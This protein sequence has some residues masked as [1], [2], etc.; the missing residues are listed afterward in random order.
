MYLLTVGLVFCHITAVVV[1]GQL[2]ESVLSIHH[3]G[4]RESVS[5]PGKLDLL[6]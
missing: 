2:R 3:E 5:R 6:S 4:S 1:R